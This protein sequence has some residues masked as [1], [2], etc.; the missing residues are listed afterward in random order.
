MSARHSG[1]S[2]TGSLA[3]VRLTDLDQEGGKVER[4]VIHGNSASV[5]ENGVNS[6]KYHACCKEPRLPPI[7]QVDVDGGAEEIQ[8]EKR[9][10]AG[11][12]GSIA[13]DAHLNRADVKSTVCARAEDLDVRRYTRRKLCRRHSGRFSLWQAVDSRALD[14][15]PATS[16]SFSRSGQKHR[17]CSF[18]EASPCLEEVLGDGESSR[19]GSRRGCRFELA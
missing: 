8:G 15:S 12:A 9:D 2:T 11:Q 4:V 18:V 6:P 3:T 16:R 14:D 7:A 17:S 10:V 5:A 1:L 13:V 19:V